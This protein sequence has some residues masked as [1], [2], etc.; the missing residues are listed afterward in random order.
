MVN[1]TA[2]LP[3]EK[4]STKA[5]AAAGQFRAI[6]LWLNEP[7]IPQGVYAQVCQDK[8]PGCIQITVEFERVPLQKP[9][10]QFICHLIW[11]LNSPLIEGIHLIARPLGA[12][13]PLWQSRVRVMTPALRER[14]RREQGQGS[15]AAVIPPQL[16]EPSLSMPTLP[17]LDF[18]LLS[19]HLK[20]M[21]ALML[22]GSA[23]AAFVFG[24]MIEVVMS[25]RREPSL[26]F[27][28][29]V[30]ADA[31]APQNRTFT[32]QP[33]E[34]REPRLPAF[35]RATSDDR[36][37]TR[38]REERP[39]TETSFET[40][41]VSYRIEPERDRPNVVNAA[42]E[43]V[44][45]LK[46]E[47]IQDP[48]DPTVTM[49]FSGDV[50][51]DGL[52]YDQFEHD[53]QLLSGLPFYQKADLAVINLQDPLATAATSLEEELLEQDRSEAINL[54]KAGGVDLVNLTGE[55]TLSYGEQGLVETL[56]TLDRNGIFRVG[57]GRSDREARRPEI[58]D[59]KGQRIAYL[60]YDRDFTLAAGDGLSGVNAVSMQDIVR[61]IRAIRDEVDWLVVKY[62]WST[63][64][65]AKPAESQTN[66]A[67][68]AIDQ[69]AD[70][71]VGQHPNQLQGAELYKGRPIAYS[72]GDFI[73]G[74]DAEDP[75]PETAV[76]QVSLRNGQMKVDLIP[77]KV[78]DGQ[79]QVAEGSDGKRIL[80][81]IQEASQEFKSPMPPS[82]VLDAFSRGTPAPPAEGRETDGFTDGDR[83]W[84]VPADVD[85]GSSDEMPQE[86]APQAPVEA[87]SASPEAEPP[88]T[89]APAI[90]DEP[91]EAEPPEAEV[92]SPEAEPLE[93]GE[94]DDD[95][96]I[97][98]D[99]FPEEL[100]KDWGPKESPN[101]IYEPESRLP[102]QPDRPKPQPKRHAADRLP[103]PNLAAPPAALESAPP[104]SATRKSSTAAENRPPNGAI[105]PYSEPLVGPMSSLSESAP[106]MKMHNEA[107]IP[108]P[109]AQPGMP[110][111]RVYVPLNTL[112]PADDAPITVNVEKAAAI[113]LRDTDM[114]SSP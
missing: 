17:G 54:L 49:L 110:E 88:E 105:A 80:Q 57:A 62:R 20:T 48:Q 52:P 78:K 75:T 67:R 31:P 51:L 58:I 82:I 6:A 107:T 24:C 9:L 38:T 45:V 90:R 44:G 109:K 97:N 102:R 13:K 15:P 8:R 63:E 7:L 81:T 21:R 47:R 93:T 36:K 108:Q 27:R 76:L 84:T 77:V 35:D 79:P 41:E 113:A 40:T 53:G 66:L 114:G 61:D 14:L 19:E 33:G 65:P 100:L 50:D 64:P 85:P 104:T 23:V 2:N 106:D 95:L 28:E 83:P 37:A 3:P 1:A 16:R 26:P 89:E 71:V 87:E 34:A 43:P 5:L 56:D 10:T 101:T 92:E 72:L 39:E 91:M 69:G 25:A 11:Q 74:R 111:S 68:L 60:S 18:N 22:T 96:Q 73:F 103:P 55:K 112:K 12:H 29:R 94:D 32:A 4:L 42:L 98:L 30:E 59:V 70:L 46:H 86:S 99:D